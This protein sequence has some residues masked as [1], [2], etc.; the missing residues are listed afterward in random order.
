MDQEGEV[1]Q[2]FDD[3]I[4]EM[5]ESRN[6]DEGRLKEKVLEGLK[7][8]EEETYAQ[9]AREILEK[10]DAGKVERPDLAL[11]EYGAVL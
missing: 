3:A 7:V 8:K 11:E 2:T 4:R 9:A 10:I 1:P 5:A 6:L